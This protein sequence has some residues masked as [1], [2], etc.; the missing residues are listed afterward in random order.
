MKFFDMGFCFRPIP[1]G[2][3][4]VLDSSVR[5]DCLNTRFIY[6]EEDL[7][8]PDAPGFSNKFLAFDIFAPGIDKN[9]MLPSD[10]VSDFL[11]SNIDTSSGDR[12]GDWN[13]VESDSYKTC[14]S[15]NCNFSVRFNRLF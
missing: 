2:E 13:L 1:K 11:D 7:E 14:T 8:N 9:T 4:E 15:S 6:N 10:L 3:T 12:S 5:F